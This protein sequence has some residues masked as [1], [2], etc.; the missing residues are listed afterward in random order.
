MD[1]DRLNPGQARYACHAQ[2]HHAIPERDE[3]RPEGDQFG[4]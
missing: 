4:E 1:R 3:V 2:N